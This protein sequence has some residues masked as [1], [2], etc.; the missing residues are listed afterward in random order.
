MIIGDVLAW[1]CPSGLEPMGPEGG[2]KVLTYRVAPAAHSRH[3]KEERLSKARH[4]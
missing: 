3:T 4:N 2:N 1:S